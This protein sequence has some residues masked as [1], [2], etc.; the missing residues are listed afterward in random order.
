M[1]SFCWNLKWTHK[2]LEFRRNRKQSLNRQLQC[3]R[4]AEHKLHNIWCSA[5][6]ER[7]AH[8]PVKF[9]VYRETSNVYLDNLLSTS[10]FMYYFQ[11]WDMIPL[12]ME[13]RIQ[14]P[15]ILLVLLMMITISATQST[16]VQYLY[17]KIE[18]A[19]NITGTVEAQYTVKSNQECG[20]RLVISFS[21]LLVFLISYPRARGWMTENYFAIVFELFWFHSI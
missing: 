21:I 14:L 5:K 15:R 13:H 2:L 9:F 1:C 6:F 4:F 11:V 16:Y 8:T 7:N 12:A 20:V 19:Q 17:K 10:M 3:K 18:L